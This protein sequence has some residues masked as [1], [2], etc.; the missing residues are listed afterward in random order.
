[1]RPSNESYLAELLPLVHCSSCAAVLCL[2]FAICECL[3]YGHLSSSSEGVMIVWWLSNDRVMVVRPTIF[4]TAVMYNRALASYE[5]ALGPEQTSTLNTVNNLG[6]L[7][8]D[9]GHLE[10]A[11]RMYNCALTGKEKAWGPEH[12]STLGTVKNIRIL[13]RHQGHLKDVERMYSRAL[14]GKEKAF[15]H[16]PWS[17]HPLQSQTLRPERVAATGQQG[18]MSRSGPASE[19][20]MVCFLFLFFFNI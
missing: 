19:C 8:K 11:E 4:A 13:Y 20:W 16:C 15:S 9:Q 3:V 7:Y 5:M 6:L 14:T 1:M 18:S 17:D 12:T 10:D 2:G